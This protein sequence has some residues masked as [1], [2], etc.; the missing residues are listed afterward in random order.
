MPLLLV[1]LAGGAGAGLRFLVD[2]KVNEKNTL[3]DF[4]LG[5][6]VVNVSACFLIG[7]IVANL[8]RGDWNTI[9]ATGLVGGYSTFS[10]AS[11]DA[12]KLFLARRSL[13][14]LVHITLMFILSYLALFLGLLLKWN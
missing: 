13:W 8:P 4:P 1:G 10:T 12:A 6:V 3:R 7:F 11:L 14:A 2:A 5:T 9:L